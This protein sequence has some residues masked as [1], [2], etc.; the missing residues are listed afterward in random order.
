LS[1]RRKPP[2]RQDAKEEVE[3]S[4]KTGET[5]HCELDVTLAFDGLHRGTG[6]SRM[7]T[8]FDDARR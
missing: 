5:T 8:M 7:L 1:G 4:E 6:V 3:K 2:S